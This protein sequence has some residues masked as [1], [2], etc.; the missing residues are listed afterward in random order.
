M[1]AIRR[2]A[3]VAPGRA[4]GRPAAVGDLRFRTLL[5]A[6][7]WAAL[8]GAVRERFAKKLG[9]GAA[10]TYVGEVAECRM[11]PAGWLLAQ[12]ARLIGSPLPLGRDI[13]VPAVVSVT[14]DGASGGQVWTRIYGRRRG[15][16]QVIHSSK[17]FAGP[18][19]LEEY[20]GRGVGIALRVSGDASGI[21]FL[22]DH[23][24]LA[25]GRWRLV[26]PRWLAPGDLTILHQDRER[27]SFAFIL[28][29]DHPLL[30]P[31]IHQTG[32]FREHRADD[33]G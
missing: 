31:L 29:L 33:Q 5:G 23:Y 15:F 9:G 17:R 16:P 24:F 3:A 8:P 7:T 10:V 4:T 11:A 20:L 28:A 2:V 19:G 27:G 6:D 26:L 12:L 30:G 14:E 25:I 18:T 21:R 22:S 13:D 32:I 1:T